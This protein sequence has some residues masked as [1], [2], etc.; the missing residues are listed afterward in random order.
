QLNPGAQ[1]FNSPVVANDTTYNITFAIS[2]VCGTSNFMHP[3]MVAN[4]PTANFGINPT[5]GC[6]PLPV[7]IGNIS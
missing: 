3:V 5:S 4:A 1:V 7:S 2:N 6:S